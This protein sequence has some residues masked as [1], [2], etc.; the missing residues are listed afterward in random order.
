[1]GMK[2]I[3]SLDI[4]EMDVPNPPVIQPPDSII[5]FIEQ[6]NEVID[7]KTSNTPLDEEQKI[8]EEEVEDN[9]SKDSEIE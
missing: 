7:D 4:L 2:Q 5:L 6:D 8:L 3:V 1:M 9:T